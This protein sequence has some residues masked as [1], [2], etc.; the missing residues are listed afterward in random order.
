MSAGGRN[1]QRRRRTGCWRASSPPRSTRSAILAAHSRPAR[2]PAH[3]P[4]PRAPLRAAD[5]SE[6][7]GGVSAHQRLGVVQRS[8]QRRN[9]DGI[10][11]VAQ[12]D[13][14]VAQQPASLRAL[15]RAVAKALAKALLVQREQRNQRGAR[16]R[17]G[18]R[19]WNSNRSPLT[20]KRS[21]RAQR[22]RPPSFTGQTCWQMSQP[23]MCVA[24]QRAQLERDAAAQL[25]GEVRDAAAVIQHVGRDE[26]V[27]R[28]GVQ[29]D[30]TLA[31]VRAERRVRRQ[32]E[33]GDDLRQKDPR[34]PAL[35][36]ECTVFLPYQPRPDRCATAR[37]T[38]RPVSTKTMLFSCPGGASARISPASA[39]SLRRMTSW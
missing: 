39:S 15:D 4:A 19:G 18:A 6:R 30:L 3:G 31:T 37:S 8:D 7:P 27:G 5:T 9:R 24:D 26:R 32:V 28:A 11:D 2:V 22:A 33:A 29:A 36:S 21:A 17:S 12:R 16:R 13:T 14:D 35:W 23:K 38:I 25:D 34:S 10:A 1:A 20:P